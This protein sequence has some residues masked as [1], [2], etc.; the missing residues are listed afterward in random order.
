MR[1]GSKEA[2][3]ETQQTPEGLY[4]ILQTTYKQGKEMKT[5]KKVLEDLNLHPGHSIKHHYPG[6]DIPKG[7]HLMPDGQIMKDSDHPKKDEELEEGLFSKRNKA[8]DAT[9]AKLLKPYDSSAKRATKVKVKNAISDLD[10]IAWQFENQFDTAPGN[11]GRHLL[12]QKKVT[13]KIDSL[14]KDLEALQKIL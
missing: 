7:Y 2:P 8:S 4:A 9:R 14:M 11:R 6:K 1:H 13:Q 5:F 12:N 3:T 10:H